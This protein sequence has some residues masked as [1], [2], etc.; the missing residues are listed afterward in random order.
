MISSTTS[1]SSAVAGGTTG[2]LFGRTVGPTK[3]GATSGGAVGSSRASASVDLYSGAV[4][5]APV[6]DPE[7]LAVLAVASCVVTDPSSADADRSPSPSPPATVL[8]SFIG[9]RAPGNPDMGPTSVT[10]PSGSV[11]G[12]SSVW[13]D[14]SR[15]FVCLALHQVTWLS[16]KN[17]K[18]R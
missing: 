14:G 2:G 16:A 7:G 3:P 6:S 17:T 10:S 12:C 15:P 13:A 1:S 18:M 8:D 11:R 5:V 9:Y 4:P